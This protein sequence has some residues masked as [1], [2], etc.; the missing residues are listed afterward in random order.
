[1]VILVSAMGLKWLIDLPLPEIGS[2][3]ILRTNDDDCTRKRRQINEQQVDKKRKFSSE[4]VTVVVGEKYWCLKSD[5][6]V[7]PH[8][9]PSVYHTLPRHLLYKNVHAARCLSYPSAAIPNL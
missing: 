3:A 5:A 6:F 1:L 9:P 4:C 7:Y 2:L 8:S